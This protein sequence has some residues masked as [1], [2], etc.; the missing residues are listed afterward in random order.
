MINFDEVADAL[1][2]NDELLK[3]VLRVLVDSQSLCYIC[4]LLTSTRA[5]EVLQLPTSSQYH[6]FKGYLQW[7]EIF[8][9]LVTCSL[10]GAHLHRSQRIDYEGART[11]HH[12]ARLEDSGVIFL[13]EPQSSAPQSK[14]LC[15][16]APPRQTAAWSHHSPLLRPWLTV[17]AE[18][19]ETEFCI[20]VPFIWIHLV[21]AQAALDASSQSPPLPQIQLLSQLGTALTPSEKERL[22]LS[23]LALRMYF[24]AE[25]DRAGHGEVM[26][27]EVSDLFPVVPQGRKV[28]PSHIDLPSGCSWLVAQSTE[29]IKADTFMSSPPSSQQQQQQG[30]DV[31][32]A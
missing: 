11:R 6:R 30:S 7:L 2:H 17:E 26:R 28:D 14:V 13:V 5:L 4:I 25:C 16:P 18:D 8:P 10:F 1:V 31:P 24:L 29:E 19:D 9:L 23:V 15:L 22:L 12:I 32:S 27:F 21:A 20:V 3:D